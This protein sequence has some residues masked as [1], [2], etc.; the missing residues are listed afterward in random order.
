MNNGDICAVGIDFG[1]TNSV[2]AIAD[3][4]G[5]VE[6]LSWPSFGG[7]THTFRTAL[8]FWRE[9]RSLK[10]VAGPAALQRAIAAGDEQRFIQSIK[11]YLAS[12]FFSETWLYGD[13]FTIERLVSTFLSH[14][15]DGRDQVR[16]LPILS[17]RPVVFAGERPDEAL[18][19]GRLTKAYADAAL[20]QVALAYEPVGAAYWYARGLTRDETVLVADF[21]GGTSDFSVL[22][23]RRNGKGFVAE[24]LAHTGVGVAGDT[25]DYRIVT[26]VVAPQLGKGTSYRSFGKLLPIPAYFY[27]AFAQWHQLSWL[28][29]SAALTEL[30]K[31]IAVAEAPQ[32]LEDLRTMI[33]MD[34]G[35]DLYRVVNG[36]KAALSDADTVTFRFD[37][38]GI[39]IESEITRR[40]FE[41]W[42]APDLAKLA[43]AM[44]RAVAQAGLGFGDI[45]AV[46]LTGG[47]SFVPAVRALFQNRFHAERVHLGDA[48][49]SVAAGLA[50]MALDQ[51][52]RGMEGRGLAPPCHAS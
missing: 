42:I 21:G 32:M 46:F 20:P 47:T 19:V 8:M 40:D 1:T 48:F 34:L 30:G 10:H 24:P 37:R 33:E 4:S 22:R 26:N 25:F 50:L 27:S 44:E 23:F 12:P 6:T 39:V 7:P 35:F 45:D 49:Q 52:R 13:R 38:E 31:L 9:G 3:R 14:L 15:L 11:T 43:E 36:V 28:K 51:A 17:G 5:Q 41:A 18:A 2:V 29:S 16:T